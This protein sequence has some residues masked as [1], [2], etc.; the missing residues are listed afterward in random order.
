MPPPGYVPPPGAGTPEPSSP[1]PEPIA[2]ASRRRVPRRLVAGG[3]AL[4]AAV[5]TAFVVLAATSNQ[6]VDP[7]AQAASAS[8]KQSGFRMD[9]SFIISSPAFGVLPASASAVVDPP[10]HTF[11]MSVALDYSRLPQAA[12][13]LGGGKFQMAMILDHRNLYLKL[14]PAL[15]NK[16]PNLGGKP[17]VEVNAATATG[18]PGLPSLGSGSSTTDPMAMLK[19]LK[20]S[21]GSVTNEGQQLVDGVPTTHYRA[22]LSAQRLLSKL[23]SSE[24]SLLQQVT[25]NLGIPVDV[26][27]DAHHL[28][29]RITMSLS[30]NSPAGPA[31]QATFTANISHYGPQPRPKLPPADQVTDASNLGA[32]LLS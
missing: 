8:S 19:Q 31:L 32:G 27:I 18:L 7:I 15:L 24:R 28:V 3:L 17:W 26:W 12:Q 14:P 1:A 5:A 23:P 9:M 4:L 2:R 30:V 10:A 16:V 20:A 22:E 13:A 11:S 21:V 6:A 25:S 29:R